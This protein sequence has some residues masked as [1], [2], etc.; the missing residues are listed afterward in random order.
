MTPLGVS[1]VQYTF[2]KI[3]LA[4]TI[5]LAINFKKSVR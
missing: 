3:F 1:A 5:K 4:Y 2:L